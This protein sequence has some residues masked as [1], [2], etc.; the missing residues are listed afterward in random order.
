VADARKRPIDNSASPNAAFSRRHVVNAAPDGTEPLRF[1]R[2]ALW[3]A[4]AGAPVE[5]IV[6][7]DNICW[8][9]L[10]LI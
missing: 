3:C 5:R 8:A 6:P 7:K 2:R 10:G 9:S 4:T 1:M